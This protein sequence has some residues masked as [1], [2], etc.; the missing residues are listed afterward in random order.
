MN[1]TESLIKLGKRHKRFQ[2]K[3]RHIHRQRSILL[4]H[5]GLDSLED[6]EIHRFHKRKAMNC[7]RP[8]CMLCGN[9]RRTWNQK[10]MQERKNEQV[11][12][13]FELGVDY[14]G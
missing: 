10:T 13:D 7:G 2:Q 14:N 11:S 8:R 9:P 6:V 5:R 1:D 3:R 4:A 12:I